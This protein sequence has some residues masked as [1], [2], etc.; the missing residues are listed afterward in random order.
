VKNF[1][2]ALGR[3]RQ[4]WDVQEGLRTPRKPCATSGP[5]SMYERRSECVSHLILGNYQDRLAGSPSFL[6]LFRPCKFDEHLGRMRPSQAR[7]RSPAM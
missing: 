4:F 5:L 3:T 1:F 2:T 7:R 6:R